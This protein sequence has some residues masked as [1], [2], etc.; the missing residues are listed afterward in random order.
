MATV[1]GYRPPEEEVP[2][3][4]EGGTIPTVLGEVGSDLRSFFI[5]P[6]MPMI[7]GMKTRSPEEVPDKSRALISRLNAI[8]SDTF[9][10]NAPSKR[11]GLTLIVSGPEVLIQYPPNGISLSTAE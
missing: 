9:R 6:M 2:W 11:L 8:T 3:F 10:V 7:E 1:L 4:G 5:D